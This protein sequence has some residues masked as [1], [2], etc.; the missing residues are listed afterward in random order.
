MKV[1]SVKLNSIK[2]KTSFPKDVSFSAKTNDN[3]TKETQQFETS[4]KHA[5]NMCRIIAATSFTFATLWLIFNKK[6]K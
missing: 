6:K 3:K 2:K 1:S 4:K 5:Q